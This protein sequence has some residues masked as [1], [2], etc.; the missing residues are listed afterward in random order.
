MLGFSG[1]IDRTQALFIAPSVLDPW[2]EFHKAGA[3]NQEGQGPLDQTLLQRPREDQ[4]D[5]G[6]EEPLAPSEEEFSWDQDNPNEI[7]DITTGDE[8]DVFNK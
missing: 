5:P 7:L 4:S 1:D 3:K 2:L 8:V 6:D